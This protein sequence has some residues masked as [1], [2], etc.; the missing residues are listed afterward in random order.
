MAWEYKGQQSSGAMGSF[1]IDPDG[2]RIVAWGSYATSDLVFTEVDID[3]NDL[4]DFYFTEG[5]PS[6]RA[7]KVPLGAFDL[8][9]LRRAAGLQ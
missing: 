5:A 6:Y 4:L 3:G 8:S 9:A 7:I 2:S 1:R